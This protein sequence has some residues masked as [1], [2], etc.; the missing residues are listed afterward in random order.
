MMRWSCSLVVSGPGSLALCVYTLHPAAHN[1]GI[2]DA[3]GSGEAGDIWWGAAITGL[4]GEPR[5]HHHQGECH[6]P[7]Q[8]PGSGVTDCVLPPGMKVTVPRSR[9][10]QPSSFPR[11]GWT[12][13]TGTG[14]WP[15]VTGARGGGQD[16]R[17]WDE[18][19]WPH[20]PGASGGVSVR[21]CHRIISEISSVV[22]RSTTVA[23]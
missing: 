1:P 5:D 21:S 15:S 20:D 2:S 14:H 6:R 18:L 9:A 17:Q 22:V 10:L 11:P 12:R 23:A 16:V 19:R 7:G 13:Q 4:G 8:W 3:R